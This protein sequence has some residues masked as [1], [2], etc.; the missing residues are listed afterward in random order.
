MKTIAIALTLIISA[1]LAQAARTLPVALD[2][3]RIHQITAML[4]PKAQCIGAPVTQR[5]HWDKLSAHPAFSRTIPNAEK[6]LREQ[7]PEKP[8]SLVLDYKTTGNRSRWQRVDSIWRKRLDALFM[9]ECL[10]NKGRFLPALEEIITAFCDEP[11]WVMPAHD[12]G[13]NCY[14][15]KVQYADLKAADIGMTLAVIRGIL[16]D[17]LSAPL[18]QRIKDEVMRRNLTPFMQQITGTTGMTWW[19]ITGTNNWNAVCL[20]GITEA[21]LA[22]IDDPAERALYIVAAATYSRFFLSGFTPDGYCSEGMG[23][24]N[25]GYGHYILLTEFIHQATGGKVDLL[26]AAGAEAAG[27]YAGVL[28]IQ[29]GIHP[30]FADCSIGSRPSASFMYYLSRRYGFGFSEWDQL[31]PVGS[32][33]GGIAGILFAFPTSADTCTPVTPAGPRLAQ[34]TWFKDAGILICRPGADAESRLAVAVKG[35]HNAEHHNHNDVGSYL[36]VSG[37]DALLVDP[38]AEVY[39][40]RT[41]SSQRYDSKVLNSFGH[42]VP[43]VAGRMQE[44]GSAARGVVLSTSFT[45]EEDTLVI[46]LKSAYQVPELQRLERTFRYSR[47]GAGAFSV[48]DRVQFDS[49]QSFETALVTLSGWMKQAAGSFVFRDLDEGVKLTIAVTG[50]EFESDAVK[51]DEDVRTRIQP[52]RI[53]IRFREPV[54]EAS[55]TVTVTPDH[56]RADGKTAALFNGGFELADMGWQI[57]DKLTTLSSEFAASGRSALRIRDDSETDGSNIISSRVAVRAGA[58]MTLS[59]KHYTISGQGVGVYVRYYNQANQMLNEVS[60]GGNMKALLVLQPAAFNTWESFSA[61]FTPPPETAYIRLWIHS[62]NGALVDAVLDDID[63]Q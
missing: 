17:K 43:L 44:K 32:A 35:G 19:W 7:I 18:R 24:W 5:A 6:L 2:T 21:A 48:T 63:V 25:Y 9:A 40:R 27:R 31:D 20:A 12:S 26:K 8:E 59:G 56:I 41:F 58:P 13:Q 29:N 61:P 51:I 53:A 38:G 15:G 1:Q 33:E 46:D 49:P 36:V 57:D 4:P 55:V 60:A 52:T 50:G 10:E 47:K 14:Y 37:T 45:D 42:S 39:T 34:R 16:G 62:I 11:T 54:Q 3:N 22:L 28:E 30:A 23:Y